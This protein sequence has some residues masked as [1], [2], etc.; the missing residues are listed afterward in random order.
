MGINS[1]STGVQ[2]TLDQTDIGVSHSYNR[3]RARG[4]H[5]SYC[6]V[7]VVVANIAMFTIDQDKLESAACST[8]YANSCSIGSCGTARIE[9]CG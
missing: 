8:S 5:T 9:P 2:G 6:L 3:G 1:L 4:G 7:H